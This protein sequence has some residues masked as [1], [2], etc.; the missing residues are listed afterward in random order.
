VKVQWRVVDARSKLSLNL[1]GPDELRALWEA[2]GHPPGEAARLALA[3]VRWRAEHAPAFQAAPPDSGELPLRPPAGAFAAVE[4]LRDVPGVGPE[5]YRRAEPH[6]TVASD[7]RINLNT[8]P[9]PVLRTLPEVDARAARAIVAKRR[10][11]PL[12]SAYEL[13]D[14]LP[15]LEPRGAERRMAALVERAAFAPRHAEVRSAAAPPGTP[16]RGR[17]RAVAVLG[18]A[19]KVPLVA[20]VER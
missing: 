16:L 6:L 17:I 20:V 14:V 15:H 12:G 2:V 9:E 5:A 7:G 13:A 3:V 11:R 1:A 8:A 10:E 4:E 19:A 18:I